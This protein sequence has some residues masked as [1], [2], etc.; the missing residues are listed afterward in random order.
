MI[1]TLSASTS[2]ELPP[3]GP[4]VEE[5]RKPLDEN[6]L[7]YENVKRITALETETERLKAENEELWRASNLKGGKSKKVLTRANCY[8]KVH[9]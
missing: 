2:E 5:V 7:Q 6:L 1:L 8:R 9:E 3:P 4:I